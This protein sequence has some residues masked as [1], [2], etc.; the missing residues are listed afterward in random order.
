MDLKNQNSE[1]SSLLEVSRDILYG[2][3]NGLDRLVGA[4]NAETDVGSCSQNNINISSPTQNSSR[5]QS[6][7]G[8]PQWAIG[9]CK[10][11]DTIEKQLTSQL[12]TQNQRWSK[13]E[14][15]LKN[16]NIRMTNIE[17]QI[18]QIGV[19]Q[20]KMT[21]TDRNLTFLKQDYHSTKEQV[22]E[23]DKSIQY[24][25]TICDDLIEKNNELNQKV[26][27][28][29]EKYE[30]VIKKQAEINIKQASADEKLI[31]IQWRSMRENLLFCGLAEAEGENCE[32]KVKEFIQTELH[33]NKDIQLDRVHRLGRFSP[34]QRFHRPIVAKFTFFKDREMVRQAAP[35]YLIG[36]RFRVKEH[37]PPEIEESRKRLYGEAKIARQNVNN[38]VKLVRDKLFVNGQQFHPG[39]SDHQDPRF[40]SDGSQNFPKPPRFGNQRERQQFGQQRS[41]GFRSSN[42]NVT[43]RPRDA[44]MGSMRGDS[45]SGQGQFTE[46]EHDDIG[47][48]DL[49]LNTDIDT[50]NRYT[51]LGN[52]ESAWPT[53]DQSRYNRERQS[54][55][56]GKRKPTSPVDSDISTKRQTEYTN[57][58]NTDSNDMECEQPR[59][60]AANSNGITVSQD[61]YL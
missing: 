51:V 41:G 25:S 39:W 56:A 45:A 54:A 52:D 23:H 60:V 44:G 48:N 18:A 55:F 46:R 3:Q 26:N 43:P 33:I 24:Q 58:S 30:H 36:S 57:N 61:T 14:G 12:Q 31:D 19:L 2:S 8:M 37:F 38:R 16:Q 11:L 29:T 42:H 10:Q 35:K 22:N 9:M 6:H 4:D 7:N 20:E 13:V 50:R 59:S 34:S 28:L 1:T 15:Q 17:S 40:N 27:D 5:D 32:R 47:R 53:P 49:S 21:E